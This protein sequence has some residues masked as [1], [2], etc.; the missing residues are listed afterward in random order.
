VHIHI[1]RLIRSLPRVLTKRSRLGTGFLGPR[2]CRL[3]FRRSSKLVRIASSVSPSR[4]SQ[5]L[6]SRIGGGGRSHSAPVRPRPV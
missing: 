6:G 2:G 5:Q 4:V 3:Y 1:C